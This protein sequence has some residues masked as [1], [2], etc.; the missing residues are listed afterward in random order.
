MTTDN[1]EVS[2]QD[3][4]NTEGNGSDAV[5]QSVPEAT[6]T[7][8]DKVVE[9]TEAK[10]AEVNWEER[11]N[12][13]DTN[14]KELQRK[15][16]EVTQDRAGMKKDFQA[17]Q[18]AMGQLQ[19]SVASMS[20]KPLPSPEQFVQDIQTNGIKAIQPFLEEQINPIRD[21]H[22]KELATRDE[23]IM[24]LEVNME[25]MLRR[26]D[27]MKYP[28]FTKLEPEI[29]RMAADPSC[30]VDFSK[31]TGEVID[32]LYNLVRSKHSS[33]ALLAAEQ[34]GKQKAE[35]GLAKESKTTVAGGGKTGASVT[36]DL[37]K[38]KD[39]TKMREIV[40]G[41]HGVAERD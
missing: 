28:D 32:T 27:G 40:A 23:K 9:S 26:S 18:D 20:K 31:P 17:L 4:I 1:P 36:P 33:D 10:P 22:Q 7:L 30:P 3:P 29:Q 25:C 24:N 16:T 19:S 15:F 8:T 6:E 5:S 35:E 12:Q 2:G 14:Y 21:S 11:Y 39:L 38:V 37:N 41:M 34:V 13:T